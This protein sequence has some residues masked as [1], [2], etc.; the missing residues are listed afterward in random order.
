MWHAHEM[1]FG[2]M[3]AV[4]VGFLFTAGRVAPLFT[5]AIAGASATK[6]PWLEKAALDFTQALLRGLSEF[7]RAQRQAGRGACLYRWRAALFGRPAM[8]R[9]C[10]PITLFQLQCFII[11]A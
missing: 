1:L 8:A 6:H 10:A 2:F 11:L 4:V 3:L 5:K 7:R 9:H